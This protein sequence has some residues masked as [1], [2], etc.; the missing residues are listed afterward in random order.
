VLYL[1]SI[2][3]AVHLILPR[4]PGL[5]RSAELVARASPLVVCAAFLAEVSSEACYAGLLGRAVAAASRAETTVR[6][7]S[8]QGLGPWFMLRLT[9]CG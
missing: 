1:A 5:E 4:I 2:G 6:S 8:R 9:V 7:R 3:L